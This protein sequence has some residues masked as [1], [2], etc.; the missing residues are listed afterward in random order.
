M[1]PE[2]RATLRKSQLLSA[3]DV[4]DR[5]PLRL[6]SLLLS[7]LSICLSGAI[8]GTTADAYSI[9]HKESNAMNPWWLPLW[10]DHFDTGG[11]RS[12]IG[13]GAGVILF[14]GIYVALSLTPKLNFHAGSFR[15]ML[16]AVMFSTA[17]ALL[18]LVSIVYSAILN[19]SGRSR[20]TIQTWTCR[21]STGIPLSSIDINDADKNLTND[22]FQKVCAESRFAFWA[23]VAVVILQALLFCTSIAQWSTSFWARTRRT[24][25]DGRPD[26]GT[27]MESQKDLKLSG[28]FPKNSY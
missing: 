27:E 11:A 8:I 23:L 12:L 20:E 10:P 16:S 13:A 22:S 18:A 6:A 15:A 9:Y 3:S 24:L 19:R 5:H 1:S 14:N 4:Q 21:F 2:Y 25:D 17:S 26:T 28:E 7:L